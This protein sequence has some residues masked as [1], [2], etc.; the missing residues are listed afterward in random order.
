MHLKRGHTKITFLKISS[1]RICVNATSLSVAVSVS[2]S[3]AEKDPPAKYLSMSTAISGAGSGLQVEC[4][5]GP[6]AGLRSIADSH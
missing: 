5:L 6:K 1:V 3:D 4:S 2:I